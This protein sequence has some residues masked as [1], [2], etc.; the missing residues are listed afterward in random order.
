MTAV[1]GRSTFL[2]FVGKC[3]KRGRVARDNVYESGGWSLMNL[4]LASPA[5]QF[6][7]EFQPR[8]KRKTRK[9]SRG[10]PGDVSPRIFFF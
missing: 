5:T 4:A 9:K 7:E 10:E 1:S 8:K 6:G 2:K 3:L